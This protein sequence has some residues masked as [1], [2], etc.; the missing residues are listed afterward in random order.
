MKSKYLSLITAITFAPVVSAQAE[1]PAVKTAEKAEMELEE[2]FVPLFDGKTLNGWNAAKSTG[3]TD[4]KDG[5]FSINAE[6][7]AIHVYKGETPGSEQVIDCIVSEKQFSHFILKIEYK[8]LGPRFAPRTNYERDAGLLFHTH[9]DLKKVWPNCV[10]MQ[11]GESPGDKP[12]GRKEAGRFHTG[13]LFVLGKTRAKTNVDEKKRYSPDLPLVTTKN[14]YTP[15][16]KEKPMGE[17]NEMEIRVYGSKEAIFIFNG[18]EV[19]RVFDMEYNHKGKF[20][21]LKKGHIA[22]QA[23]WAEVMYRNIRVKELKEGEKE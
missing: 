19:L 15:K 1:E 23:E 6:E 4:T 11:I 8:W 7:K 12:Q 3:K 18:E 9:G 13:D 21:P 22:L 2:G 20:L 16:G 10:E 14:G 5:A 17:W